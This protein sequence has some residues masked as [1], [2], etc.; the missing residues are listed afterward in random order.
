MSMKAAFSTGEVAKLLHVSPGTVSRWFD[1]GKL[2]GYFIVGSRNRRIPRASLI[3]F[4]R[5]NGLP[6]GELESEQESAEEDRADA[7]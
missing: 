1:M 2:K 4:C 7:V 5:E 6:L 3:S